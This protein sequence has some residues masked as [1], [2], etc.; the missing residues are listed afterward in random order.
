MMIRRRISADDSDRGSI[1]L[2]MLGVLIMTSVVTVGFASVVMGQ[3]QTRHQQAFAQAL[4]GAESGLDSMIAQVKLNPSQSSFS[5]ITASNSTTGVS[6]TASASGSNGTWLV[7]S[8]GTAT[9]AGHTVTRTVQENVTLSGIYGVPLFG[10]TALTV[11]AGSGVNEYDSGT[12]GTATNST[13][14]VLPNTGV[15]GSGLAATTMC[16][17][18]ISG[19]GPAATDGALT[20]AG[21]DLNNF[22]EID[23][24]NVAS[25]G[26][27]N[28]DATGQCVGDSTAC[29]SSK[30]KTST[31]SLDYPD[32][33]VCSNGIGIDASAISGS[34]Y[35]AAGAVYRVTGDLTLNSAVV[36]NL[37][38]L[39]SSGIT[40]CFNGNLT[41]PSLGAAGITVPW[42]S[43]VNSAVP[44]TYAPRPPATLTLIDTSTSADSTITL[45]D[46]LNPETALSAVIY[47][48]HATCTTNGHVDLYGAIVCGSVT[49]SSGIN[50]HYDQQLQNSTAEQ[51]VTVANWREV[52]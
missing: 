3:H 24:D 5:P 50:V 49:A 38:N 20:M 14:S 19:T 46:G 47:A 37:N 15:L 27:A 23:V 43:T 22:S 44:L 36:A 42:N 12:N 45:G 8:T 41:V 26:Y 16:T 9:Y 11:R 10:K 30:V 28:P 7:S 39:A 31:S 13:C 1:V 33:T 40:L 17:P 34:N 35:L 18:T 32:S 51:T 29:A 2:A 25:G 6:Y 48:P 21:S 4:T 52:H